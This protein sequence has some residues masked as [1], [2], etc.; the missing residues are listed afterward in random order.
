LQQTIQF[1]KS[2]THIAVKKC[3]FSK[4][5]LFYHLKFIVVAFLLFQNLVFAQIQP[6]IGLDNLPNDNDEICLIPVVPSNPNGSGPQIGE[7]VQDFNLFDIDGNAHRLSLELNEDVPVL[8]ISGSITCPVFRER[9]PEINAMSQQYG[10]QLRIFIIYTVEAHPT[11]PSPYSGNVW[12][13]MQN[14]VENVLHSQPTTYGERKSLVDT[15]LS[16]YQVDVDVLIDGPCNNW[17]LNYGT[18]ANN[19]FLINTDG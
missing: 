13:T 8:L 11:D 14:E 1:L 7:E 16:N 2:K 5:N 9:L 19:A 15:L 3:S 4:S 12:I 17:W 18:G 10:D 6:G